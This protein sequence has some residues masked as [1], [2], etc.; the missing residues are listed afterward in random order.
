MKIKNISAGS[1]DIESKHPEEDCSGNIGKTYVRY[2]TFD[3][4]IIGLLKNLTNEVDGIES[5]K[6]PKKFYTDEQ[7]S[8][9]FDYWDV[10]EDDE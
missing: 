10:E 7:F 9:R 3:K 8:K 5:V 1:V 6:V 4:Y 2:V